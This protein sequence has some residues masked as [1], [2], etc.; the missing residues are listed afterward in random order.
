MCLL[1]SLV[2][3][4]TVGSTKASTVN[5]SLVRLKSALDQY[6]NA[7]NCVVRSVPMSPNIINTEVTTI[8]RKNKTSPNTGLIL[9]NSKVSNPTPEI[10]MY[11][12]GFFVR[13]RIAFKSRL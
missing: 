5:S 10:I 7:D 4:E 9:L 6:P 1:K 2:N 3:T 11:A 13:C 8:I 12:Y